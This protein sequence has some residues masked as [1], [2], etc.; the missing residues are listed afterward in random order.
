MQDECLILSTSFCRGNNVDEQLV[1]KWGVVKDMHLTSLEK[2]QS[3]GHTTSQFLLAVFM[4]L[5]RS[6]L[7][8]IPLSTF[9]ASL[10]QSGFRQSE[11][12]TSEMLKLLYP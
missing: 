8:R 4:K 10:N 9:Q 1:G 5:L 7:Q 12:Y 6:V 11:V 3:Q 2:L